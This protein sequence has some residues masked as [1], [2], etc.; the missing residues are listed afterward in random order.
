MTAVLPSRDV[1]ILQGV[2]KVVSF[3]VTSGGEVTVV[4][5]GC[6]KIVPW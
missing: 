5:T 3:D 6:A 2:H 4:C 1:P